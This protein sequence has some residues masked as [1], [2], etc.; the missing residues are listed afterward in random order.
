MQCMSCIWQ[1]VLERLGYFDTDQTCMRKVARRRYL[2]S[3]QNVQKLCFQGINKGQG[4]VNG[5]RRPPPA[6]RR[7]FVLCVCYNISFNVAKRATGVWRVQV[8]RSATFSKH[9]HTAHVACR[10]A[11]SPQAEKND[12]GHE[13]I[14]ATMNCHYSIAAESHVWLTECRPRPGYS[15]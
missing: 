11:S 3:H 4:D 5:N 1:G 7:C 6:R 12:D 10:A 8:R 2:T 9:N 14:A 15:P 13:W